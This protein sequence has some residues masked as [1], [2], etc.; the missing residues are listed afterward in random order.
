EPREPDLEAIARVHLEELEVLE[1]APVRGEARHVDVEGRLGR[2][3]GADHGDAAG[4]R[5]SRLSAGGCRRCRLSSTFWSAAESCS[6]RAASA[7]TESALRTER[8]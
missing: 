2:W 1:H 4:G 5:R 7:P 8:E 6:A 3:G